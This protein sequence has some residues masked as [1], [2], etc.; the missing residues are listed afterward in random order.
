MPTNSDTP[1]DDCTAN[2]QAKP[3][4]AKAKGCEGCDR[5]AREQYDEE[6]EAYK[7]K[8]KEAWRNFQ[9]NGPKWIEAVCAIALVGITFFYTLYAAKQAKSSETAAIAAKSA[10]ETAAGELEL[11]ERPWVYAELSLS[12]PLTFDATGVHVIYTVK[13]RNVG[14][15]P[16]VHAQPMIVLV[17]LQNE[18]EIVEWQKR[19]GCR[20]T[21]PITDSEA[22]QPGPTIFPDT[23]VPPEPFEGILNPGE[24]EKGLLKH[25]RPGSRVVNLYL[26]GCIAYQSSFNA[27]K[28]YET[29]I[30]FGVG[31]PL[32]ATDAGVSIPRSRLRLIPITFNMASYAY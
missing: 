17:A 7:L 32:L 16:A 25:A 5:Y 19:M 29:G 9:R 23:D 26:V 18:L 20:R 12:S 21:V 22:D 2:D 31:E 8:A 15:S 24:I 10:A 4:A 11:S 30:S 1:S 28:L 3:A 13:L 14:R 6:Y 27:K